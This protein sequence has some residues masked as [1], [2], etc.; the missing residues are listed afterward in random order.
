MAA[1]KLYR[2]R[3]KF[4]GLRI[5]MRTWVCPEPM[6]AV[7]II[8]H[9]IGEHSKVYKS[10]SKRFNAHGISIVSF[11]QR[12]HG[13]S[14]GKRG[15]T[16]MYRAF[17]SDLALV[18]RSTKNLFP[19][20]PIFVY[21]HSMGGNIALNF[22]LKKRRNVIGGIA[23]SPW[24]TLA[25]EPP[26]YKVLLGRIMGL[27]WPDYSDSNKTSLESEVIVD[28]EEDPLLHDTISITTYLECKKAG[29]RV[30]NRSDNLTLPLLL[31]HGT[32]DKRTSW[33]S[34][35]KLGS[36]LSNPMSKFV[37]FE[38]AEHELHE[39]IQQDEVFNTVMA[40][41]QEVLNKQ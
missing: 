18:Y 1:S 12:G 31:M 35:A 7:V 24:L 8:V 40:W 2:L 14:G 22:L 39:D 3:S 20:K 25:F 4:D 27:F 33:V 10:W 17:L 13:L 6:E 21:G 5:I 16:P 15:H 37:S 23:S 26:F 11:D 28:K 19:Q 29:K 38:Q 34:T 30:I 9:G 32:E 36:K 41:M